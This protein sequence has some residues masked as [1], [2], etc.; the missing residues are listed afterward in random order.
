MCSRKPTRTCPDDGSPV[1]MLC[2]SPGGSLASFPSPAYRVRGSFA[3]WSAIKSVKRVAVG[4]LQRGT[5][6]EQ[7]LV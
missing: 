1:A 6:D 5:S 3:A 4:P 2:R 7:F